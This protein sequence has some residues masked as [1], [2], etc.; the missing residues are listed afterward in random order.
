MLADKLKAIG[1]RYST[2]A[3]ISICINDMVIPEGKPAII[4]QAPPKK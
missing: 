1:F 3:G 4:D 2:M